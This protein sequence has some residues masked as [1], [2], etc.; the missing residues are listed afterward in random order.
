MV[1][2]AG[3]AHVRPTVRRLTGPDSSDA[4]G[5]QPD[6]FAP[7]F[8]R[9]GARSGLPTG[10]LP[11]RTVPSWCGLSPSRAGIECLTCARDRRPCAESWRQLVQA[12]DHPIEEGGQHLEGKADLVRWRGR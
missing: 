7:S 5:Y 6:G 11:R 10:E 3:R 4:T 8:P 9:H 12:S 1:A 2:L